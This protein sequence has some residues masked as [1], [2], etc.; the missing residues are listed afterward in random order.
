MR[1]KG[2]GK[3]ENAILVISWYKV[4]SLYRIATFLL[5]VFRII[6]YSKYFS[7]F[8]FS[9]SESG[10][11]TKS[12]SDGRI[13]ILS[14]AEEEKRSHSSFQGKTSG[15]LFKDIAFYSDLPKSSDDRLF[16]ERL[17]HG[18]LE[19][20]WSVFYFENFL[21]EIEILRKERKN[22]QIRMKN[23]KELFRSRRRTRSFWW[24]SND[25]STRL[26]SS[27]WAEASKMHFRLF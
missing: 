10:L 26:L 16:H 13:A 15:F 9:A 5:I 2:G 21:T 7:I 25:S 22:R 12:R 8:V 3:R 24:A 20:G 6:L 11:P 17:Q 14:G 19:E 18:A 23:T 27:C 1:W 4:S